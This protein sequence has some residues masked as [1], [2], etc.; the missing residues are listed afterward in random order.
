MSLAPF[1]KPDPKRLSGTLNDSD[2]RFCRL[3][4][5]QILILPPFQRLVLLNCHTSSLSHY[6][7]CRFF[8][9]LFPRCSHGSRLLNISYQLT[10][11]NMCLP[12]VEPSQPGGPSVEDDAASIHEVTPSVTAHQ[13]RIT[14]SSVPTVSPRNSLLLLNLPPIVIVELSVEDPAPGFQTVRDLLDLKLCKRHGFFAKR[15]QFP[16]FFWGGVFN[17]HAHLIP[18]TQRRARC[19]FRAR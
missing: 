5:S 11:R 9:F 2:V 4:L 7:G 15:S 16:M 13:S 14:P 6:S 10:Q 17:C 12:E 19:R 1:L 8:F 3:R 18:G